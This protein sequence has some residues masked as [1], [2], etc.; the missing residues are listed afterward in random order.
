[1]GRHRAALALLAALLVGPVAACGSTDDTE[2]GG[3]G[4]T[5]DASA[6]RAARHRRAVGHLVRGRRHPRPHR[7]RTVGRDPT[8]GSAEAALARVPVKG[9]APKTGYDRDEYGTVVD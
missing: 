9:R 1:M 8:A 4:T 7:G 3:S 6:A 5:G 2:P